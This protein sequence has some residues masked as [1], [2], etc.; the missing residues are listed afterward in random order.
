M[1]LMVRK[2]KGRERCRVLTSLERE[3]FFKSRV[4]RIVLMLHVS[5]G[6]VLGEMRLRCVKEVD[7]QKPFLNRNIIVILYQC[8]SLVLSHDLSLP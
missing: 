8:Q 7:L 3:V 6:W 2:P 5:R 4:I 1:G